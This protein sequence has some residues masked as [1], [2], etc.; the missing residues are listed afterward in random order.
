MKLR[1]L[2]IVLLCAAVGVLASC[3]GRKGAS[4]NGEPAEEGIELAMEGETVPMD[5]NNIITPEPALAF[6]PDSVA[7][8]PVFDIVTNYG[9]IRI[10]LFEDTPKHRDNFVKLASKRFYD[11][12]LFHRVINGFMIQAGDPTTKNP[13]ADRNRFGYNDA[14]YK[15]PAEILPAHK[16][17][18][19]ALCAAREGDRANPEKKSSGSQFYLVQDPN[20]CAQLDGDY[21][22]FGKTISGLEVIDKIAAV[23]TG[24]RDLPVNPVKIQSIKL[25]EE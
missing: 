7:A 20:N 18:K 23:K 5:H 15:I 3:G 6:N 4:A 21:T 10:K 2:S 22:V 16:H 25:V 19:G 1:L 12:I 24:A 14:G 17:I 11:G 13:D 8:E 9:T